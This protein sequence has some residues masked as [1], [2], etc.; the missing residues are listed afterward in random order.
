MKHILLAIFF[1]FSSFSIAQATDSVK[2]EEEMKTEVPQ[3]T[4]AGPSKWY[5]GGNIG[6][7][8]WG[9]YFSISEFILLLVTRLHHNFHLGQKLVIPIWSN[10]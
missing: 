4:P 1:T 3:N 6:F 8:F 2:A 9:D 10:R 7:S 5:Y